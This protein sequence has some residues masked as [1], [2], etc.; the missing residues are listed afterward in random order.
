LNRWIFG[1]RVFSAAWAMWAACMFPN[2]AI[3]AEVALFCQEDRGDH[4]SILI[5][6]DVRKV[7]D[8]GL[9]AP[10]SEGELGSGVQTNEFTGI[11][12][13]ASQKWAFGDGSGHAEVLL[14]VD[15]TTGH[16]SRLMIIYEKDSSRKPTLIDNWGVCSR[17]ERKF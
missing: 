5:D 16:F 2:S 3:A 7:I 8:L 15:R 12:I 1:A 14:S 17:I 6:P 4:F 13:S 11:Y 10:G 9:A